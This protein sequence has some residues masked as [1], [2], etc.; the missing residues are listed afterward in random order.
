MNG[1]ELVFCRL[2]VDPISNLLLLQLP[3]RSLDQHIKTL[4]LILKHRHMQQREALPVHEVIQADPVRQF[5]IALAHIEVA[6]EVVG[7]SGLRLQVLSELVVRV[8]FDQLHAVIRHLLDLPLQLGALLLAQ[9][10][11]I[12]FGP[13]SKDAPVIV[14]NKITLRLLH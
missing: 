13:G 3:D 7:A 12:C 11:L 2:H 14:G 9:V 8:L 4:L 10:V 5:N 6:G 1:C